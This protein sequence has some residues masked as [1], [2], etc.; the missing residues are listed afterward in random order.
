MSLERF[1]LLECALDCI[2]IG[3]FSFRSL[4]EVVVVGTLSLNLPL[5]RHGNGLHGCV[6]VVAFGNRRRTFSDCFV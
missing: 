2:V 6:C 5:A 4:N 3:L 1:S